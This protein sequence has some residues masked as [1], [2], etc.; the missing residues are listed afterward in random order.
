MTA[1]VERITGRVM[2]RPIGT[3]VMIVEDPG[4]IGGLETATP[5]VS[6]PKLGRMGTITEYVH[7]GLSPKIELDDG[8][9]LY[10]YECWWK[11]V[12]G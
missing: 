2:E 11:E 4:S 9:V 6:K 7:N 3:R 10:G 8:S 12:K 5:E 1:K